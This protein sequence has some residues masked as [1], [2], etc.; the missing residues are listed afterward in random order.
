MG[1]CCKIFLWQW[2]LEPFFF[3]FPCVRQ[4][5]NVVNYRTPYFLER[6]D[7]KVIVNLKEKTDHVVNKRCVLAW[8]RRKFKN[9]D[10]T[11]FPQFRFWSFISKVNAI[12][13]QREFSTALHRLRC[14]AWTEHFSLIN[15][16]R[17]IV[18]RALEKWVTISGVSSIN[19]K[20]FHTIYDTFMMLIC[21]IYYNQLNI[22]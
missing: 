6:K 10:R 22:D 7:F 20:C 4:N 11:N 17:R 9:S 19:R 13:A 8:T 18:S 5:L 12:S 15:N 3:S 16:V 2:V 1:C 14:C 21:T